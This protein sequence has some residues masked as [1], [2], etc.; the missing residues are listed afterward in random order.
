M[1]SYNNSQKKFIKTIN[2][3]K[4]HKNMNNDIFVPFKL[5]G[6]NTINTLNIINMIKVKNYQNQFDQ[7]ICYK[8]MTTTTSLINCKYIKK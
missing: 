1:I 6:T 5:V 3:N 7:V 4:A 8:T 2:I